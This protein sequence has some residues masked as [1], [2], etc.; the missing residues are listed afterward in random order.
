MLQRYYFFVTF[1]KFCDNYV[2]IKRESIFNKG[3]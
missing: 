3:D 2:I 1:N